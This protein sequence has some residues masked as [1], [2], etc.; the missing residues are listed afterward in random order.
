V[1]CLVCQ[2]MSKYK[3]THVQSP[4]FGFKLSARKFLDEQG[5]REAGSP[6][7]AL[8][9]SSVRHMFNAV[10]WNVCPSPP[11][12]TLLHARLPFP[13]ANSS[14]SSNSNN[15]NS[16]CNNNSS[17]L[18]SSLL[19]VP[20]RALSFPSSPFVIA[21]AGRTHHCQLHFDVLANPSPVWFVTRGHEAWVRPRGKHGVRQ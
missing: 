2:A 15:S 21:S 9:L 6:P 14:N 8:D 11:F 5:A 18:A 16:N 10:R 13:F 20:T 17:T 19:P 4:N 12:S 1:D 7:L 3:A